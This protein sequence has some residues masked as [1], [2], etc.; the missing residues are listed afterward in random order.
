M[1]GMHILSADPCRQQGERVR[2]G[3]TSN[4][5]QEGA[6]REPPAW[7]EAVQNESQLQVAAER[8]P[9]PGGHEQG[10]SWQCRNGGKVKV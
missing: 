4:K 3:L 5:M 10:G 1:Y 9:A 7:T 2:G 8:K 6:K